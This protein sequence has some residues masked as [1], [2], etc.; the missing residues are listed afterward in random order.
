MGK[1]KFKLGITWMGI[2]VLLMFAFFLMWGA[3]KRDSAVFDEKAHIPAGY[4]YVKLQDLRLNPEH[5]PL[6]KALAGFFV[7]SLQP[8]FPTDDPAW[9][10]GELGS[11]WTVGEKFLYGSGNSAREIIDRARLAPIFITLLFILFMYLCG[12]VLLGPFW[13]I[14]PA[15][16]LGLSPTV[17][18]N[19]Y[20]V[21]TDVAAAFFMFI[22]A[23]CFLNFLQKQS[24]CFAVLT[25]MVFG[26]GALAKF[27]VL[28]LVPY[29]ILLVIIWSLRARV[30]FPE[31]WLIVSR[32]YFYG[33][34]LVMIVGFIGV[35]YPVYRFLGANYPLASVSQQA[36]DILSDFECDLPGPACS[37]ADGVADILMRASNNSAAWPL[38]RYGMGFLMALQRSVQGDVV[39]FMGNLAAKG[40]PGYFPV[41]YLLKETLP[42]LLVV[43]A[44]LG[45]LLFFGLRSS[46]RRDFSGKNLLRYHSVSL[47]VFL[48]VL[49][50]AAYAVRSPLNIGYRHI[51]PLLPFLYLGSVYVLR[52]LLSNFPRVSNSMK[53][54]ACVGVAVWSA[55]IPAKEYP[56]LLS[57]FNPIGGGT[58]EG[59]R[60]ASDSSYDWGQDLDRLKHWLDL[61]PEV[62]VIAVDY[63]GGGSPAYA[64][65]SRQ[66]AWNSAQGDPR[67][68]G[69]HWLAVSIGILEQA[70]QPIRGN[71]HRSVQDEYHWLRT[72]RPVSPSMG[73]VPSPDHR[74]GVSIFIYYLP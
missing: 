71:I 32:R 22:S 34:F 38:A 26:L 49:L 74:A 10:S 66:I 41:L 39:Y 40:S 18:G 69:I 9:R 45:S 19:G 21:T 63:F 54:L 55:A 73:G 53:V 4:S 24:Y 13:A 62:D 25:G 8:A 37:L 16:L 11:Q 57:Y 65:E 35:V 58:M 61:H 36:A 44:C 59:Y 52:N 27:S 28:F 42:A 3:A 64:L 51:L 72:A 29:F 1:E 43:L 6:V 5:P 31:T 15:I 47:S 67:A 2:A 14:L 60:Y 17:L 20:Y 30:L 46:R 50:Y 70:S 48:F 23:W 33:F 68:A 7:L 12:R 56:H